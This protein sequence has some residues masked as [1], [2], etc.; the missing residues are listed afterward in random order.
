MK[1]KLRR[2]RYTI[3]VAYGCTIFINPVISQDR[4][5]RMALTGD[6][7]I[8]RK[9]SVYSEK[10]FLNMIKII[11]DADV[12]IT[13]FEMLLHDY[14]PYPMSVSGGTYMRGDP[15][16]AGEIKWAGFDMV[17]LANN[18]TGDYGIMGMQLTLQYLNKEGIVCAG[19][20]ESLSQAREAK[21]LETG[22]GRVALISCTST[23]PD[24][25]RAGN[26]IGNHPARPG[27]NPLRFNTDYYVEKDQL[28]ILKKIKNEV[29]FVDPDD[30]IKDKPDEIVF[31]GKKFIAADSVYFV[32][33]PNEID[34]KE[35]TDV[36][37]SAANLA[38]YT[39]V[40][41]HAHEAKGDHYHP[42]EF[43]VTAS[44]AMIDA[45]A[46][47]VFSHGSHMLRG[48]EIYKGKPIFYS[49]GD[50]IFQNETLLRYPVDNFEAF[51]MESGSQP[52]DFNKARYDNDKKGFPTMKKVWE[53][54]VAV[55]VWEGKKLI[56]IE[57]FPI[58]LGYGKPRIE[59]GRPILADSGLGDEILNDIKRLSE[60][61]GTNVEIKDGIGYIIP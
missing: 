20:G 24:H 39:T 14:E 9:L 35:I 46:D 38:D 2:I 53:S 6:A 27:L 40:A 42:A 50:F 52:S 51:K 8:T 7:I 54:V 25:S 29:E 11:R 19:V 31:F 43:V 55:P 5:F 18:H 44:K 61:F 56:S 1:T 30:A 13:N 49:L 28:E 12:A 16:L 17:S 45:G 48:I 4:P 37:T 23:F 21:F 41:F 58:A 32:T 34:I 3:F 36:I 59:R 33:K 57:L 15:F 22:S 26:T 60:P 47:V 10:P